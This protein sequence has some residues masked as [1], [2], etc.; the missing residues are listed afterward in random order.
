MKAEWLIEHSDN[1]AIGYENIAVDGV[2]CAGVGVIDGGKDRG[3]E[4]AVFKSGFAPDPFL[5]FGDR[6][7]RAEKDAE[8]SQELM[9]FSNLRSQVAYMLA[10]GLDSGKVKILESSIPQ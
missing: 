10:M 2:E 5:T 6:P 9:A 7:K 8:R 4:F 1:F 3:A